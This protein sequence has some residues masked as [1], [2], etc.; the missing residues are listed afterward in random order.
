MRE[1]ETSNRAYASR[2]YDETFD[3]WKRCNPDVYRYKLYREAARLH[4]E[5]LRSTYTGP[6]TEWKNPYAGPEIA[7]IGNPGSGWRH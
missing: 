5:A 6:G 7:I 2:K 4:N 1:W 3:A